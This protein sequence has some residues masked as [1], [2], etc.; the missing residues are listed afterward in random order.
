MDNDDLDNLAW[1]DDDSVVDG[2]IESDADDDMTPGV[3]V[4]LQ[5]LSRFSTDITSRDGMRNPNLVARP[6]PRRSVSRRRMSN[7]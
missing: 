7:A 5:S 1:D 4:Y 2:D 3:I 6:S